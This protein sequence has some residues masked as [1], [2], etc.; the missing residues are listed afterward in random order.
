L[1]RDG[2][3]RSDVWEALYLVGSAADPSSDWDGDGQSLLEESQFGTDPNDPVS[4]TLAHVR[5]AAAPGS[6]LLGMDT[7]AG[8]RYRIETSVDLAD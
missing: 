5:F 6:L 7:Q 2:N 4:L 3:E 1:D 8:K